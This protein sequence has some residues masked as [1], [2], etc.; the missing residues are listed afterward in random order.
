MKSGISGYL[1]LAFE[2][3][4]WLRNHQTKRTVSTA[5]VQI[6]VFVQYVRHQLVI[7]QGQPPYAERITR[8]V[9]L[10]AKPKAWRPSPLDQALKY[11]QALN[12]PSVVSKNQVAKRFGVSRARVCQML[13]LLE[14]DQGILQYLRS[15]KDVGEHNYFTERRLRQVATIGNREV[16]LAEFNRLRQ[17]SVYGVGVQQGL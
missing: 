6:P 9:I 15:I 10:E 3:N 8:R 5:R 17:K 12:E 16:Q 2:L 7:V 14:L 13:N 1:E 4:K 11:A